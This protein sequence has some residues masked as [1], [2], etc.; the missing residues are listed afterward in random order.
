MLVGADSSALYSV[1][2]GGTVTSIATGLSNKRWAFASGPVVSAQG[3]LFAMNGSDTPKQWSG[4]GSAA[5]WTN[6]SGAVAVPNGTMLVY[7][8]NQMFVSGVSTSPSRVYWSAI[9]DPTN[10]DPASLTG[11]GFMDFDPNDGQAIS[12]IG[13]VGPYLLV[14]KP[15]KLWVLVNPATAQ[16]RKLSDNIGC[17]APRSIASSEEGT[18]FLSEDRGVMLTN[19]SKVEPVSDKIMPTILGNVGPLSQ[20]AGVYFNSHYYLSLPLGSSTND[21]TLDYDIKLSTAAEPSWWKHSFGSNQF[22]VWHP[23]T[24]AQLY[25]AKAT[26]AVVDQC[27]VN[28]TFTDNGSN[29]TWV[30][31]GSWQ[32]P[33]I[34]RHH[35]YQTPEFRKRLRQLRVDGYGTVDVSVAKDFAGQETLVRSNAL[36]ANNLGTFGASDGSVFGAPDSSMFGS[37]SVQRVRIN[38]GF[39]VANAFSF[40]F[41]ATSSTADAVLS[42]M[43]T[44]LDRRDLIP[45]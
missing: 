38:A 7:N 17:V 18:F 10:W 37:P 12:A 2:S 6:A 29:M 27:F 15:R 4:S 16:A 31:R 41:G 28:N 22:A 40:V 34:Y 42:F 24:T 1:S 21:T 9:A 43:A 11:A 32:S 25:S 33:L 26:S 36:A 13:V 5:N 35:R 23:S 44:F 45:G 39:G 19:G 30:W 14:A 3:P 20:S 8:Q